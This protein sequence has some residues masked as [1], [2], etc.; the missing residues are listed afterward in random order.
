VAW[1]VD[2]GAVESCA[3]GRQVDG[4]MTGDPGDLWRFVRDS[5]VAL[6]VPR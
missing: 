3:V 1:I 6:G 4:V 5:D 2:R